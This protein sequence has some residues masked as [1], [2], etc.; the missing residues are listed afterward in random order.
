[1]TKKQIMNS[2]KRNALMAE[3]NSM[4]AKTPAE[5][6]SY[7]EQARSARRMLRVLETLDCGIQSSTGRK[8]P[9]TPERFM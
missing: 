9:D 8:S 5:A 2:I 1:M 6:R 3:L 7:R 4:D